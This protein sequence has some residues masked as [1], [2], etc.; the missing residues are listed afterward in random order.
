MNEVN[1]SLL[2]LR[3]SQ[4]DYE[5]ETQTSN[6]IDENLFNNRIFNCNIL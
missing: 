6:P 1:K 3:N 5:I 2:L 4:Q